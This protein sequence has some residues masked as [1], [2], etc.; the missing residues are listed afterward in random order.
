[1]IE[2][3]TSKEMLRR[4][5]A[6]NDRTVHEISYGSPDGITWTE[7]SAEKVVQIECDIIPWKHRLKKWVFN[8]VHA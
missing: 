6:V 7:I 1:M 3:L 2:P 8:R 4:A 5:R